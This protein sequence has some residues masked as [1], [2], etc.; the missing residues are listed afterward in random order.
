MLSTVDAIYRANGEGIES[1]GTNDLA[2]QC[3]KWASLP[4]MFNP[5]TKWGYGVSTDVLG[6]LIEVVSGQSLADF[7]ATRIFEPLGMTDARWHVDD[8]DAGRLAGLY[9]PDPRTGRVTRASA[10][11]G[12]ARTRPAMYSGGAGLICTADDYHRFTRMLLGEGELDGVRLLG[13][14]TVRY[15][16]RSHL[17]AGADLANFGTG[18]FAESVMEGIGFGLGLAV[19]DD[20]I[21]GRTPI[22]AGSYYWGGLA[23]TVF[24]VDPVEEL[25]AMF[26]TQLMPSSTYPIRSQLRQL[27][28]AALR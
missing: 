23:S 7:F 15:M 20:P 27:V 3:R 8:I 26:F 16:T 17:P 28:Y 11:D 21:P 2:D 22:T 13:S 14:R 10:Y 25:T 24:W 6:R 18:G 12:Y 9:M 4:L 1:F 5:G 19:V